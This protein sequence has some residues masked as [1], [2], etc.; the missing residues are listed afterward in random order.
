MTLPTQPVAFG[1]FTPTSRFIRFELTDNGSSVIVLPGG[2]YVAFLSAT[3]VAFCTFNAE[4][5]LPQPGTPVDGFVLLPAQP[6]LIVAP[7][8]TA[9]L[10]GRL[11]SG[12]GNGT[13]W[14]SEV[15]P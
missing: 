15:S 12:A 6:A 2:T 14:L 3:D 4:A 10:N 5:G 7:S 13:L 8:G 11:K 1:P 9:Q